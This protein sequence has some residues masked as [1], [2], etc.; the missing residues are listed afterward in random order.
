MTGIDSCNVVKLTKEELNSV[1]IH[2]F[3][4]SI[5]KHAYIRE[6]NKEI[7]MDILPLFIGKTYPEIKEVLKNLDDLSRSI[8]HSSPLG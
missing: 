8:L 1:G 6:L 3:I 2:Y 5:E 7:I 4:D